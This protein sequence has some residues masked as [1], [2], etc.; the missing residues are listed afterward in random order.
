MDF[1]AEYLS[2]A[3]ILIAALSVIVTVLIGWQITNYIFFEKRM[4]KIVQKEMRKNQNDLG[5]II[6]GITIISNSK[7]FLC[8]R[9]IQSIDDNM[10][11]LEEIQKSQNTELNQPSVNFIMENLHAAKTAIDKY[12]SSRYKVYRGRKMIYLYLLEQVTHPYKEEIVNMIMTAEEMD[13]NR[14]EEIILFPEGMKED[15]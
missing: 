2:Y 15:C 8:S 1:C 3:S 11:A 12:R 4:R 6:K 10:L 13:C 5:H 9:F 14:N 7:A